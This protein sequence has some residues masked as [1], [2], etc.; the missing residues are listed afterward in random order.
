MKRVMTAIT[1]C[2]LAMAT[3]S[4]N[5]IW[6]G[7]GVNGS[8]QSIDNWSGGTVPTDGNVD[9]KAADLVGTQK[10]ANWNYTSG[11]YTYGSIN[12]VSNSSSA[13]TLQ[14]SGA[15]TM[16]AGALTLE[17]YSS[18]KVTTLAVDQ[19]MSASSTTVKSYV[20]IN[21]ASGK[22]FTA[23]PLTLD[24]ASSADLQVT[25]FST[26]SK[27]SMDSFTQNS[28]PISFVG[29]VVAEVY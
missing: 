7:D 27:I 17:G 26:T 10:T 1:V 5:Y 9:I 28:R 18:S 23:G 12:A 2:L 25:G 11:S 24:S 4:A 21:I 3:A 8:W 15:G 20:D 13:M 14:K 6:I 29:P 19:N 16:N 22:T